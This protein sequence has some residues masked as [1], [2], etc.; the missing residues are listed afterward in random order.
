MDNLTKYVLLYLEKTTDAAGVFRTL[1][2]FCEEGGLPYYVISDR[3]I[4]FTA[5][6]IQEFCR[7]RGTLTH[8]TLY[9]S[10]HPQANGLLKRENRKK[11]LQYHCEQSLMKTLGCKVERISTKHKY[12][13][14]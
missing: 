9:F 11:P 13:S 6:S 4:F 1:D 2:K 7:L 5:N 3:I 10:R 12:C 8:H 14:K